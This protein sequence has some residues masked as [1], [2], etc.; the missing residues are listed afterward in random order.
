MKNIL[1][2]G[3][4]SGIGRELCLKYAGMG[5]KVAATGRRVE[6]L[7]SLKL[8]Q[9]DL[10]YTY[11]NDVTQCK[12]Q[13]LIKQ[14]SADLGGLDII[15]ISSGFGDIN[16][17]LESEVEFKTVNTNV[18][19]FTD[20]ADAG[21]KLLSSQF[22]ES[23]R[24]GVLAGLSSI[25]SFRGS[26]A[27]PA[28]FAS[29]AYVSNYLQGLRK[30]AI[31][32]KEDVSIVTIIPGFVDTALGKGVGGKGLFWVAPVGKAA[33][34]IISAVDKKKKVA[35]I[36]KRWRLMAWVLKLAPDFIYNRTY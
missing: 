9:P 32:D 27:A 8:A 23:G 5:Y 20:W 17:F 7:A 13:E 25:A 3:A 30:K 24:K 14:I 2:I 6:L 26:D 36:T 10:I 22:K 31:K 19:G 18:L 4:T 35:Y 1:V 28:Y 29:K 15:V 21:Y 34:Q 12:A 33:R 11:T 16:F